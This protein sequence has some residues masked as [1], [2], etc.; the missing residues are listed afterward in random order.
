[1]AARAHPDGLD[2]TRGLK[3]GQLGLDHPVGVVVQLVQLYH[4]SICLVCSW[5]LLVKE[6]KV[7]R[8]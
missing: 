7:M 3:V 8:R 1:M 6:K 5:L 2:P 4:L